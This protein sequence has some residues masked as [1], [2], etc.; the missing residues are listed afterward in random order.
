MI[1]REATKK[2]MEHWSKMRA[3]LWP[4]SKDAHISEIKEYLSG[5]S[6]D[7]VQAYVAEA[8]S[9]I[10]GFMELNIRNFSEGS[11]SPKLPY[12]EAWY[13]KPQYQ[14]MGYGKQLM[15]KAEQW[16]I[17]QGYSELASDTEID[18]HRSIAMHKH[19][20][21]LETERIVCFLKKLRNA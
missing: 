21:F 7:I 14:G 6:I 8:G 12:V 13:I 19:L 20:G 3:A 1:I 9:E 11:R 2:D 10:V 15:Q 18:N 17:S 4:T 16:A 5:S